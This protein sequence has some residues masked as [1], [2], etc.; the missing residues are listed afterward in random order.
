MRLLKGEVVLQHRGQ[1]TQVRVDDARVG[2]SGST[3]GGA[4]G[5]DEVGDLVVLGFKSRDD[6]SHRGVVLDEFGEEH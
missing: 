1:A 2:G 5:L 3:D 4:I 6:W